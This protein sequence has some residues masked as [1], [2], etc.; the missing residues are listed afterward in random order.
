MPKEKIPTLEIVEEKTQYFKTT[1]KG[2]V[3]LEENQDYKKSTRRLTG[4]KKLQDYVD[5]ARKFRENNPKAVVVENYTRNGEKISLNDMLK[6]NNILD[7]LALLSI[8][9]KSCLEI[10][11]R[12][13][14]TGGIVEKEKRIYNVDLF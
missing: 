8:E 13:I 7:I 3:I 6:S 14:S 4:N 1:E 9:V 12:E 11:E 5:E 10:R 2:L